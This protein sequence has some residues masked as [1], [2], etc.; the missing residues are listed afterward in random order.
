MATIRVK[1]GTTAPTTANL[2]NVGELA[3]DYGNNSLYARGSSSV[4]KIG[5]ELEKVFFYQGTTYYRS[6]VYPFDPDYVYKVHVIASTNGLGADTSDSY[7]FY[8]NPGLTNLYGSYICHHVN[9]ENTT[10]DVRSGKN[11]IVMYIEDSYVL[12]PTITSGIT[13]VIDFEISPTFKSSYLDTQQW[14]AYGKSVTT[15]SGQGNTSI[16]LVEFV[17]SVCGDLGSLYINSGL[18]IGSP[19][20]IAITIYRFKRK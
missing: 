4:V 2:T 8:R 12:G 9:T 11:T 18:N 20:S 3:F 19:D 1:R 10:H 15:L 17:H 5:G 16:K 13:K 7:I 14:V 6:I